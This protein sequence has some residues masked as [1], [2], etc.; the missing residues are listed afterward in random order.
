MGD[1]GGKKDKEKDQKQK[2]IKHAKDLKKKK[3][4]QPQSTLKYGADPID[5][6]ITDA[7]HFSI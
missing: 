7:F 4:K 3:A 6:E 1:K 2:E 5:R